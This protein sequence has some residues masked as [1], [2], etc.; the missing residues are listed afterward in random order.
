[1]LKTKVLEILA[2]SDKKE[3]ENDLCAMFNVKS[4]RIDDD[5]MINI[6]T[7]YGNK[8]LTNEQMERVV[9]RWTD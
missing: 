3:L 9:E 4:A 7:I 6:E 2:K 8:W 5:G 1:M